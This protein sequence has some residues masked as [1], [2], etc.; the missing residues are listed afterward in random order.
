MA[1]LLQTQQAPERKPGGESKIPTS[2]FFVLA[3]HGER[4]RT[5]RLPLV[6]RKIPGAV[7]GSYS[8]FKMCVVVEGT[9]ALIG[10][11]HK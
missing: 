3:Q 9:F 4:T 6:R 5:V 11:A 8:S 1:K 2:A 10:F 7:R